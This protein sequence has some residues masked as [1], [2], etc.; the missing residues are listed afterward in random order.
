MLCVP[1]AMIL[2]QSFVRRLLCHLEQQFDD[3][4]KRDFDL[5]DVNIRLFGTGGRTVAKKKT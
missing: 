2:G 4:A 3:R 1:E 5:D